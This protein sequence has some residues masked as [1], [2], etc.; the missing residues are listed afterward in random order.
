M[1]SASK[2]FR[3]I[4]AAGA[5]AL[6]LDGATGVFDMETQHRVWA[7]AS[8]MLHV[9]GVLETVPGVNNLMIVFD[10]LAIAPEDAEAAL[11]DLWDGVDPNGIAGREIEVPVVYGGADGEDLAG[12]AEHAGFTVDEMIRRHSGATYIVAAIG[13]MPGFPYL[14]GLDPGLAR[15][16][17]ADPRMKVAEGAVIIGGTQAG[18]MPCTA[19]SGWHILGR[20]PLKLFDP[21]RARPATLR[22]GDTVRFTVAGIAA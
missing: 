21:A 14:V 8:A 10:P 18:I 19:P 5:G 17:R 12:L 15:G 1:T 2:P 16:R 6:L 7:V 9:D 3:K 22:P 11:A 13:A 4:S 20:T